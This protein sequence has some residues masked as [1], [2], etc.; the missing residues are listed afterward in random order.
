MRCVVV[1]FLCKHLAIRE[2]EAQEAGLQVVSRANACHC[3]EAPELNKRAA[4]RKVTELL[5][6]IEL[7]HC[8]VPKQVRSVQTD[9]HPNSQMRVHKG[10]EPN[11]SSISL[12]HQFN[13]GSNK[14]VL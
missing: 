4:A 11:S 6:L 14:S 13:S 2:L 1:V 9:P 3:L 10:T 5:C 12:V 8:C 7:G